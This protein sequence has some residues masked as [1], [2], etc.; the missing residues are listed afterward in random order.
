MGLKTIDMNLFRFLILVIA[1]SLTQ[2]VTAQEQAISQEIATS[3]QTTLAIADESPEIK[4]S[5]GIHG[6]RP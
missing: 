3:Q 6:R 2:L 1:V 4:I 5:T